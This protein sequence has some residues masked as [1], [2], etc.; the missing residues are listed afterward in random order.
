MSKNKNKNKGIVDLNKMGKK[1]CTNDYC[2]YY[3]EPLEDP[4]MTSCPL[5]ASPTV[6]EKDI[7]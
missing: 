4:L 5:C 2:H 6:W 1:F 3:L 7:W